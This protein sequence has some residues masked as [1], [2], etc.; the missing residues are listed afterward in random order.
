MLCR[1]EYDDHAGHF[2]LM[3]PQIRERR[4]APVGKT[5]HFTGSSLHF[6]DTDRLQDL[7]AAVIEK[8]RMLAEQIAS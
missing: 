4:I 8:K 3:R 6:R 5:D 7:E 1:F 2:G